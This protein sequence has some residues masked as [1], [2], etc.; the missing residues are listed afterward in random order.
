MPPAV[1]VDAAFLDWLRPRIGVSTDSAITQVDPYVDSTL[2]TAAQRRWLSTLQDQEAL[3]RMEL[4]QSV[5]QSV[6]LP[7][8][9]EAR[10]SVLTSIVNRDL[11]RHPWS[12]LLSELI[13]LFDLALEQQSTIR[14]YAD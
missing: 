14:I 9:V 4:R 12:A 6:R 11:T 3:L 7:A 8:N 1:R 10:E 13:S 2:D 5:E